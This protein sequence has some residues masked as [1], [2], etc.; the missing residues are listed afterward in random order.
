MMFG[1]SRYDGENS[2]LLTEPR[3]ETI[4][5]Q[6]CNGTCAMEIDAETS[7]PCPDCNGIGVQEI[8][9]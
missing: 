4:I 5:C 1:C 7:T 8:D 6:N 2:M 3:I 9:V